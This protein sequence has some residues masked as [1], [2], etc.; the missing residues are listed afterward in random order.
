MTCFRASPRLWRR[1]MILVGVAAVL[2][3]V[4]PGA[5]LSQLLLS[6]D[7]ERYRLLSE[8]EVRLQRSQLFLQQYRA[9]VGLPSP[10]LALNSSSLHPTNPN[11]NSYPVFP[12]MKGGSPKAPLTSDDSPMAEVGVT[13][14]TMARGRRMKKGRG[15]SYRTQYL[16][17]SLATLLRLLNDTSLTRT[18]TL[19]ICNIDDR[20]HL[21]TEAE[22]LGDIAP[23][24]KRYV[25]R[26]PPV[27]VWEKLKQ[28]YVFCMQQTLAQGARYALLVEDDAVA[29]PHLFHVL[30]HVLR[31]VV[32]PRDAR[33]VA[34]L[35]LY[36]PQRLLGYISPEVERLVELLA[37][38]VVVGAV[39]TLTCRRHRHHH[40]EPLHHDQQEK[41]V[42]LWLSWA[43]WTVVAMVLALAVGRTNLMELRRLSPQL[44]QVTPTPSC[45]IPAVLYTRHGALGLSQYLLNVTCTASRS[46]DIRMDEFRASSGA[47]GLQI[48]PN[49]FSHIGMLSSLRTKEV[50]PLIVS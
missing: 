25:G 42:S 14:L 44:Y 18:Y 22:E 28:D 8:N 24:F 7:A 48:Q 36:H 20:P 46:T 23:M 1:G 4:M 32:E 15:V 9:S 37:L 21:F 13:I 17:Q 2:S 47:R 38:G 5:P 34:Y 39:L 50:N 27:S 35:K 30:E 10:S 29:H 31:E 49:L 11:L 43:R 26:K 16:T 33:P 3:I 45:C 6:E 41:P 40:P 19:T 12:P